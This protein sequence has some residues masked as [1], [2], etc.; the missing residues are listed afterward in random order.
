MINQVI[1]IFCV[2]DE[3]VQTFEIKDDP[4]TLGNRARLA[5]LSR[6]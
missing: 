1:T 3:D 4:Q 5:E 2:C 6:G